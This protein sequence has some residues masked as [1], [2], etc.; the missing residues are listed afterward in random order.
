MRDM[1]WAT[2]TRLLLFKNPLFGYTSIYRLKGDKT[3]RGLKAQAF[4]YSYYAKIAVKKGDKKSRGFE[5][6]QPYRHLD[7]DTMQKSHSNLT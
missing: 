6:Q 7:I 1:F 2:T 5:K 3:S 4:G